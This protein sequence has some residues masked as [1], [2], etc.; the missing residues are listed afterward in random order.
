VGWVGGWVFYG[1]MGLRLQFLASGFRFLASLGRVF[2]FRF[3]V[4]GSQFSVFYVVVDLRLLA[5]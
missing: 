4:P 3:L 5:A 2:T 1:V